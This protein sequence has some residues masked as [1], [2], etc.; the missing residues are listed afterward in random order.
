MVRALVSIWAFCLVLSLAGPLPGATP[1]EA[2]RLALLVIDADTFLVN[3]AC[4]GFHPSD[5]VDLRFFSTSD[6]R[7][8]RE[9]VKRFV[10]SSRV[11][12]V[13]V[14]GREL[15]EFLLHEIDLSGKTVYALRGST[16][17]ERLRARGLVFD[18]S[19]S[20][21]FDNPV[22]ENIRNMVRLVV[23]RHFDPS[24]VAGA[25][26]H[27]PKIGI[28]HP[29]AS[30]VFG[31]ADDYLDWY[32]KRKTFLEDG[33]WLGITFYSSGL[34]P[35]RKAAISR[36]IRY[37]EGAGFNVIPCFGRELDVI[38]RYLLDDDGR[39]RV[40]V[41]L[42]FSLKFSSTMTR[43]LKE[44]LLALDVPVINAL[45]L[46]GSTVDR[47]RLDP[48][49]LS[50]VEVAWSIATPEISGLVE[51][52]VLT[53]K[54][55]VKDP[56]GGREY[57]VYECVEENLERLVPRLK[58]WVRL[59]RTPNREKRVA[60]FFYN[61]HQ[62]KQNVGAS[63][64]NV[65]ESL[66]TMLRAMGEAGYRTGPVPGADEIKEMILSYGRNIG[67]WAPGELERMVD[68]GHVIKIPLAE[69][70]SWFQELPPAFRQHV[71]E[72]W[73]RPEDS[74]I[75]IKDGFFIV[76]AVRAGNVLLL[77]E[78][79]RGW[80]DD[81]MK[82]YHS[83]TLYP[84]HQYLAVYLWLSKVFKAH[85]M[86]HLGTHATYEWTPGKQAGLSPS[87][88]PSVL[89]TSIPDIYPYIVDDVGEGIQAKRRGRGVIISHLI[90]MLE[91]SG[92][93]GRYAE[94]Y[95]LIN[96]YLRARARGSALAAAKLGRIRSI[97]RETGI[98]EDLHGE[99]DS[100]DLGRPE[101]LERVSSY[102]EDLRAELM[103]CGLHCFGKSP[104]VE[105]ARGTASTVAREN[106]LS[107]AG[108]QEVL[109]G[110]LES[111][112]RELSSFLAALD[113][114]YVEPGEGN[115]PVR[116]PASL[117]TGRDFYGFNPAR[118]PSRSAWKLGKE[119]AEA[120]LRNHLKRHGHYPEKVAVVL[121]A[122][123]TMRN[124]GVN[125]C[126]ILWLL[127]LRPVWEPSG[128]VRGLEVVPGKVL[129]RPRIDVLIN[130]SGLY[131]D[132]F[133]DRLLFLDKAV[134]LA[135][136][137]RDVENLVA[138]HTE[139]LEKRLVARGM[140]RDAARKLASA[141]IFSE[142]P[143]AYGTGVSEMAAASGV[144]EDAGEI[145]DVYEKRVGF[146]YGSGLWGKEAREAFRENLRAVEATVHSRSSNLYA[147][148]DNDDVFQYLGGL[149]LAVSKESGRDPE[150]LVTRQIRPGRAQVEDAAKTLG[151]ELRTRYLNP[152]WIKGMMKEGY[153]GAREMAKFVENM[154]GW[155]VTVP[156]KVGGSKW[157]QVYEVYVEDRYHLGME[158]FFSRESPWAYQSITARMLEAVR[159][160][161]WKAG[162]ERLR[163]LAMGYALSVVEKGV[164]C[165]EH[166][167]NNPFLNQM[168]ATLISVPGLLSPEVVERFKVA[169]EAAAGKSL[170]KQVADRKAL[171]ER[172]QAPGKERPSKGSRKTTGKEAGSR[173]DGSA[174]PGEY[175]QDVK[176]Y[177]M[178][179]MK[180]DENA[181]P[182]SSGM[183]WMAVLVVFLVLALFALG[184]SRW[185]RGL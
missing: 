44:A 131:R 6:I 158:E 162:R 36:V 114:R 109:G 98:L 176:G 9:E 171:Q 33:P 143:G 84:H 68:S 179:E 55:D 104:G 101:A 111:G 62:G 151:R 31:S 82:L 70:K 118:V 141:R 26:R 120:I 132:L 103:P 73:G 78:P 59:R 52:T 37:L 60:I 56:G 144:W 177:R 100:R 15:E 128:R 25:V 161:Y 21:Y 135:A 107:V 102:L 105:A 129:G 83:P 34:V 154:W 39:P 67:A 35:G 61:H 110:I 127:G 152:R 123:E 142:G 153:A 92:L 155:Q 168:V 40:D 165:C 71:I 178:E 50:P 74:R 23:K 65:F 90:P 96:S 133:P 89:A 32:R 117:P 14:M 139:E 77:P 49:G 164:A 146:A 29:E 175:E 2:R 54:V 87:C 48:R 147:A 121:W 184:T 19:V 119:A 108:E 47:W 95:D 130:P 172:L 122:T 53:G 174:G 173:V 88:S 185:G 157:D 115:D 80:G 182:S 5:K 64:L 125:E 138:V 134:H 91:P 57:F 28:F 66:E 12:I 150:V 163:R 167:C 76:P 42:A 72:Q 170:G 11:I 112:R 81:P 181:R 106:G 3:Q 126:S 86:V 166:T 20:A 136:R 27:V 94:L 137:Q 45:S 58:A 79:A 99:V 10:Q 30:R 159:K 63:Y 41:L 18:E 140:D 1:K 8:N 97:V 24:V 169:V 16:D 46:Y 180:P 156:D 183:E 13:D 145:V 160:G 43:E 85:A 22:P 149:S 4:K 69:Y 7:R 116:N 38:H 124:E 113:G 148:M 51:P 17:D 93:Y 75:M